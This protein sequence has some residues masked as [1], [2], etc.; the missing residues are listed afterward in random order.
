[1][2]RDEYELLAFNDL[3]VAK[4]YLDMVYSVF[5][6]LNKDF[7]HRADELSTAYIGLYDFTEKYRHRMD[8]I[9]AVTKLIDEAR[10]KHRDVLAKLQVALDE[11]VQLTEQ[12]ERAESDAI[13]LQEIN[14][15]LLYEN[16]KIKESLKNFKII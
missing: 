11:V 7:D 6:S 13:M 2:I 9:G 10:S 3:N 1:M 15:G 4:A 16:K 5:E 8:D 12:K 14:T